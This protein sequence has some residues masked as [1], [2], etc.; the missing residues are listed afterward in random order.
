[1]PPIWLGSLQTRIR[2]EYLIDILYIQ[3]SLNPNS[4]R[5]YFGLDIHGSNLWILNIQTHPK[6]SS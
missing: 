2:S 6:P 3:K 1:M 4:I 5:N